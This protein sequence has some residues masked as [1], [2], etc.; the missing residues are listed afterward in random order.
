MDLIRGGGRVMDPSQWRDA[1][2]G[3]GF[4]GVKE[5]AIAAH[6]DSSTAAARCSG[7]NPRR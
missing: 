1:I 4:A 3:V 7:N 6:P 2:R 5:A